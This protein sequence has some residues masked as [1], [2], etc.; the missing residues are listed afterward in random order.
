MAMTATRTI[1]AQGRRSRLCRAA[2]FV[3]AVAGAAGLTL[4]ASACGGAAGRGVA[5]VGST[6]THGSGSSSADPAAYSACMRRHGVPNFPDP[7]SQGRLLFN[8]GSGINPRSPQFRAAQKACQ[9]LLPNGGKPDAKAQAEFLKQALKFSQCMRKH[10][11]PNFP[12]PQS[13]GS[14]IGLTIGKDS[15]IDPNSP[16][17]K[18]AQHAAESLL[19]GQKTHGGGPLTETGKMQSGGGPGGTP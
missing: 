8:S 12:D 2:L 16:R 14:G 10:G 6:T 18:P 13:S 1:R 11:I 5:Q 15:G 4:V 19:P 7:D 17:F 3:L 9:R